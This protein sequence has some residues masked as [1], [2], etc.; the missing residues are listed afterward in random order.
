M[1]KQFF[2]SLL[3]RGGNFNPS[4][5]NIA[6]PHGDSTW[7][8]PER[9]SR[10]SDHERDDAGNE[11]SRGN[12]SVN[13]SVAE[14][15]GAGQQ[16]PDAVICAL[17]AFKRENP[18]MDATAFEDGSVAISDDGVVHVDVDVLEEHFDLNSDA[19][20]NLTALQFWS[21]PKLEHLGPFPAPVQIGEEDYWRFDDVKAWVINCRHVFVVRVVQADVSQALAIFDEWVKEKKCSAWCWETL[22]GD[23]P[24]AE[25]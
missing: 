4:V 11:A 14:Y 8:T 17:E 3:D 23:R 5:T 25:S 19:I 12:D 1:I 7:H 18:E 2:R 6:E 13:D 15:H 9:R 20:D 10:M 22:L 21:H 16:P 24:N